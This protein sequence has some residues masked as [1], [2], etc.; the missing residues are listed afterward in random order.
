MYPYLRLFM[1]MRRSRKLKPLPLDGVHRSSH[2]CLPWDLD[3][4]NE[5]NNGRTLT[6]FDIGRL[7]LIHRTGIAR[8]CAEKGWGLT[9]AGSTV[10]YRRRVVLF[11]RLDMVSRCLGW[12][13]RFFYIEQSLWRKGDCTSHMLLR[14]AVTSRSGIV[15]PAEV[16]SLMGAGQ[17][18][19][20]PDWVSGWIEADALRPWPPSH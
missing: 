4:W 6:L 1:E 11:D 16:A 17:S 19:P 2:R 12:D 3:P 5:L 10:R 14:T 13:G 8:V 18:P 9:V 20:L 7:P 15:P